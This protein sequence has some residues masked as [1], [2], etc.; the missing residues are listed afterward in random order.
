MFLDFSENAFSFGT[1]V[2]FINP[3]IGNESMYKNVWEQGEHCGHVGMLVILEALFSKNELEKINIMPKSVFSFCNYF[4]GNKKFWDAYIKFCDGVLEKIASLKEKNL[5]VFELIYTSAHY[6]RNQT[7]D[8]R[9][10]I[11]ERLFSTFLLL[12]GHIKSVFFDYASD[13]FEKKFGG[14]VGKYLYSLSV[15]KND[16]ILNADIAKL[17]K[18]NKMR[19]VALNSPVG[20]W[21]RDDPT[22]A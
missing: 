5:P 1:D 20:I 19:R 8:F 22:P 16:A 11:L 6:M 14:E 17:K 21:A 13:V 9:T 10:F 15:L 18:W 4:I 2:V 12:N 3:M 7:L